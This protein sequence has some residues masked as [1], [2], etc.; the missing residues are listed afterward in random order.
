MRWVAAGNLLAQTRAPGFAARLLGS[1]KIRASVYV[2]ER[3]GGHTLSGGEGMNGGGGGGGGRSSGGEFPP[4][5]YYNLDDGAHRGAVVLATG[6]R[7]IY[8]RRAPYPSDCP[9]CARGSLSRCPTGS[10][11]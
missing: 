7:V 5:G 11:A 10:A 2:Y 3:E 4:F 6:P 1:L 9:T 8:Y